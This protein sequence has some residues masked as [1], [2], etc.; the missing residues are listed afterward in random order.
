[1]SEAFVAIS[2]MGLLTVLMAL[3]V[4]AREASQP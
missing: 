2:L 3:I 1:M 4:V